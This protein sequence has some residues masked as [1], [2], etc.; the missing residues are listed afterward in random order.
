VG[1]AARSRS[2]VTVPLDAAGCH[3]LWRE[4]IADEELCDALLSGDAASV[5]AD[6]CSDPA[7]RSILETWAANP[8]ALRWNIVNLRFRGSQDTMFK[9]RRWMPLTSALLTEGRPGWLLD[10]C[11]EY[12]AHHRWDELGHRHFAECRRFAD[13][14]TGRVSQRRRLPDHLE[15]VLTYE[16]AVCAFLERSASVPLEA[17]GPEHAADSPIHDLRPRPGPVSQLIELDEDITEWIVNGRPEG[18]VLD[19]PLR[20]LSFVPRLGDTYW[21]TPLDSGPELVF[22]RCAGR[23]TCGEIADRLAAEVGARAHDIL[24]VL[25]TWAREGALV[26]E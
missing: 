21:V 3:A 14:V 1:R 23:D 18:A 24:D 15:T 2:V 10:L 13:Y 19:R 26:L 25:Q 20:L 8:A 22:R 11:F 16:T 4:V 17:W 6:R 9:L 12:L 5:V 7:E